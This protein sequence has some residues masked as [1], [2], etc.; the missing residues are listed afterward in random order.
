[1]YLHLGTATMARCDQDC[2]LAVARTLGPAYVAAALLAAEEAALMDLDM[3]WK[4]SSSPGDQVRLN[5]LLQRGIL[6]KDR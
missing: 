3:Y 2:S 1:M 6:V 4:P 5:G